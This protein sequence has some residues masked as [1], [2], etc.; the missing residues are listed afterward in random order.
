[1]GQPTKEQWEQVARKLDNLFDS[2]VLI[3]DGYTVKAYLR[4]VASNRLAITV[5]V[6]GWFKGE[7]LT[8]KSDGTF[9]NEAV[10]FFRKSERYVYNTKQRKALKKTGIDVEKKFVFYYSHWNSARSFISHLKK[11][12]TDIEILNEGAL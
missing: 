10:K 3:C 4:R 6:N 8:R 2:A 5:Y 9:H 11:T 12:N 1:M 7:W